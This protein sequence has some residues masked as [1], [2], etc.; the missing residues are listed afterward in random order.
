[1]EHSILQVALHPEHSAAAA[2][3]VAATAVV[4][5]AVSADDVHLP[6]PAAVMSLM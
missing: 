1:M 5:V 2:V 3:D 6:P 4:A